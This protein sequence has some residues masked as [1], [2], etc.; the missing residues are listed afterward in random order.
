MISEPVFCAAEQ[1][2]PSACRRMCSFFSEAPTQVPSEACKSL[3]CSSSDCGEVCAEEVR[4]PGNFGSLGHPHCCRRPCLSFRNG[5]CADGNDCSYCHNEHL[6]TGARLDKR[7]R[8]ATAGLS[9]EQVSALVLEHC[10]AKADEAS[11]SEKVSEILQLLEVAADE[12]EPH[13]ISGR[14][15]RNLRK[16]LRRLSFHSLV[17]LATRYPSQSVH[18]TEQLQKEMELMRLQFFPGHAQATFFMSV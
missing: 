10:I 3:S 6:D 14:E 2:E 12:A 7:Q 8:A 13:S 17:H 5:Y 9:H 1:A 15:L 16:G 11:L 4:R 18:R